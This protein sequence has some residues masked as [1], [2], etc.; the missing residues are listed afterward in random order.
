[1][2][3]M[4]NIFIIFAVKVGRKM[5]VTNKK[6]GRKMCMVNKKV[7]RKM[8]AGR[9]RNAT[10]NMMAVTSVAMPSGSSLFWASSY[11]HLP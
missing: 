11:S 7:G 2:L 9:F 6:V 3:R 8:C 10:R 5:C 1:M 4:Y